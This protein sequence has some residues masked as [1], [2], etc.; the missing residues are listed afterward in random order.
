MEDVDTN[1]DAAYMGWE[2]KEGYIYPIDDNKKT[3]MANIAV[4]PCTE[5]AIMDLHDNLDEVWN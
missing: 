4:Q 3:Y 5:K 2:E 1:V